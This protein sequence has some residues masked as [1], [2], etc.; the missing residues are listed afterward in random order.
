MTSIGNIDFQRPKTSKES[1]HPLLSYHHHQQQPIFDPS[2]RNGF[3]SDPSSRCSPCCIHPVQTL[4]T[5]DQ[6]SSAGSSIHF[7]EISIQLVGCAKKLRPRR[8][9]L[10]GVLCKVRHT[11]ERGTRLQ[12]RPM[13]KL[14]SRTCGTRIQSSANPAFGRY[15]KEFDS[16]QDVFELQVRERK[17]I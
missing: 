5:N 13:F 12:I 15:E 9:D 11:F 7:C 10:R 2:L 6:E 8:R 4:H 16:V 17:A 3:A 14:R 1:R